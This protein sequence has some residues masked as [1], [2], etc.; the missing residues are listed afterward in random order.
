MEAAGSAKRRRAEASRSPPRLSGVEVIGSAVPWLNQIYTLAPAS[1]VNQAAQKRWPEWCAPPNGESFFLGE[2]PSP[3]GEGSL[4]Y[5]W[6]DRRN[7]Q[8]KLATIGFQRSHYL[9]RFPRGA[10]FPDD[11]R[12]WLPGP[13]P[14]EAD[15]DF[16]ET[17]R[18]TSHGIRV[19]AE[20][21]NCVSTAIS[22]DASETT[23]YPC[24]REDVQ[25]DPSEAAFFFEQGYLIKRAH[26]LG[27][28]DLAD[29]AL[30]AT[31]ILLRDAAD[32]EGG[33]QREVVN[34]RDCAR[35]QQDSDF[36]VYTGILR[37]S[38][39]LWTLLS[40]MFDQEPEVPRRCQVAIL[41]PTGSPGD[42]YKD[43]EDHQSGIEYHIDGRGQIPN[44]FT[45][46]VGVALC[47][48]PTEVCSWGGLTVFPGS[49]RNSELH[50]LYP[51]QKRG[52]VDKLDL[53]KG[54][55]IRLQQGDVVIAHSLL[56]HRRAENWSSAIRHMVYF[57]LQPAHVAAGWQAGLLADP[58]ANLPGVR[59]SM[60]SQCSS[61]GLERPAEGD[62]ANS[63]QLSE[64]KQMC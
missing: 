5:L 18:Q 64:A 25:L 3:K 12:A 32:I 23:P 9:C 58:F 49:H 8:W 63:S 38:A 1:A 13:K 27:T 41:F 40:R 48:Q 11:L 53:G 16:P 42:R 6:Y 7:Q 33:I 55:Q 34:L 52:E 54:M 21:G 26:E 59:R 20:D 19:V 22:C 62:T 14:L 35:S 10:R 60:G 47:D 24:L 2:K 36:S 44:K 15:Q 28:R 46:L 45:L 43:V 17:L 39:T 57:R 61:M 56:A 29:R 31:S 50:R 37:G 51:A 30:R 4:P